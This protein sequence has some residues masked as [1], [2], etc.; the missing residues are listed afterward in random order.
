KMPKTVREEFRK[1][2]IPPLLRAYLYNKQIKI[3]EF[4]ALFTL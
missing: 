4:L 2:K 1:A 3:D